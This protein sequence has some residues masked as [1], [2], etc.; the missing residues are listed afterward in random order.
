MRIAT[1]SPVILALACDLIPKVAFAQ[2]LR[3]PAS[4]LP[5]KRAQHVAKRVIQ[6]PE[7]EVLS[8]CLLQANKAK[9]AQAK[10]AT[11]KTA[12]AKTANAIRN[13][14]ICISHGED[15][16][17]ISSAALIRQAFGGEIS[18][19]PFGAAR[20]RSR[21]HHADSPR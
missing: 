8:Q 2:Q 7:A 16:D 13:K 3:Q 11:A 19:P 4:V 21:R 6:A 1:R 9:P 20:R 10:P 5:L 18:Y 14:T 15:A 12:N 17:G